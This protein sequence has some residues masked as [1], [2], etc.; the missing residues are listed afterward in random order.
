VTFEER[1]KERE[2]NLLSLG[3]HICLLGVLDFCKYLSYGDL[4]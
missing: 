3:A 1:S 4:I 2:P